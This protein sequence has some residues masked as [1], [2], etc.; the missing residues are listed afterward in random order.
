MNTKGT[1]EDRLAVRE[2]LEQYADAVNQRDA[3]SWGDTWAEDSEWSLP[4][5]PGMEAV[6]GKQNIVNAWEESMKLFPFVHMI[7]IVGE[8]RFEGDRCVCRSYTA[9]VA[10]TKDGE[11]IRP[12]GQY[13]D[14]II[15][16]NGEWKFQKRVFRVLYGE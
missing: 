16:E 3:K 1:V 2:L 12:R 4:V 5:V 15:K 7:A 10:V 11:E 13:D 14:V 9:E 6:K 8:L